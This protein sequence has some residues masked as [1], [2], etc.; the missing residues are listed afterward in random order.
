M[1]HTIETASDDT[2]YVS[3]MILLPSSMTIGSG[4]EVALL[5]LP[6]QVERL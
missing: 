5:L 6:Q 4:I 3:G 2:I 1:K